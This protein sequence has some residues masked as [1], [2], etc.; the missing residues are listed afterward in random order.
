V[1]TNL[2]SAAQDRT[3]AKFFKGDAAGIDKKE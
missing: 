3:A 1:S 2:F